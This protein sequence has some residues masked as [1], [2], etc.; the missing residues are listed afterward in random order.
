[1]SFNFFIG[2]WNWYRTCSRRSEHQS[3][4]KRTVWKRYWKSASHVDQQARQVSGLITRGQ[5]QCNYLAEF[6]VWNTGNGAL[7]RWHISNLHIAVCVTETVLDRQLLTHFAVK[8]YISFLLS[9]VV[10]DRSAVKCLC[11]T[12][13]YFNA[14]GREDLDSAFPSTVENTDRSAAACEWNLL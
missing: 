14:F 13:S 2:C 11:P 6:R 7:A 3:K 10:T 5:G 4:N 12:L 1:M 9:S 8:L